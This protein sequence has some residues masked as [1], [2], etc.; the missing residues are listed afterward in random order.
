M[1][2]SLD[3]RNF[4]GIISSTD[5][6]DIPDNCATDS[7]N[8][9]GDVAEGILQSIPTDV[10]D[11][12]N[13]NNYG[14]IS[15]GEFIEINNVYYLIYHDKANNKISVICDFYNTEGLK[16]QL[17]LITGLTSTNVS[18]TKNNR[19]VHIGIDGMNAYWIGYLGRGYFGN[20]YTSTISNI[21]NNSGN[22]QIQTS[23]ATIIRPASA[24][25]VMF[26]SIV[27]IVNAPSNTNAN[28]YWRIS[29]ADH[30]A[31]TYVL[32]GSTF[33]NTGSGGTVTE[34]FYVNY[35]VCNP[36]VADS[37]DNFHIQSIANGTAGSGY[38]QAN[39]YYEWRL[40]AVYDGVQESPLSAYPSINSYNVTVGASNIPY[41]T[42][43][44]RALGAYPTA[45]NTIVDFNR[46]I[47]AINLWRADSIDNS[48][49]NIGLFRKVASFSITDSAWIQD[50]STPSTIN[51][52]LKDYGNYVEINTASG[53]TFSTYR[54]EQSEMVTYKENTGMPE[55][56]TN[57]S[58]NWAMATSGYGYHF[59]VNDRTIYRSKRFRFDMFDW[60]TDFLILPEKP[61]ALSFYEGK[62]YAFS[63]NKT[64]RID[65]EYLS[66]EDIFDDA[67]ALGKRSVHTNEYGMFFANKYG[68]WMLF[69]SQIEE[70]T[71]PIR[72]TK[73][74]GKSWQSFSYQN[75]DEIIITSDAKKGYVLFINDFSYN[76]QYKILVW[77]YLPRTNRWDAWILGEYNSAS[78]N[79]IFKGKDGEIYL[80]LTSTT[81]KLL[82]G[83]SYQAWEWISKNFD[84]EDI[85]KK[86][87]LNKIKLNKTGTISIS[88]D[89]NNSGSFTGVSE[90]TY[91]NSYIYSVRI[92]LNAS[93]GSNTVDS[94]S[95]LFR[96]LIGVR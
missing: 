55:T 43:Q 71:K 22:I 14:N 29:F 62:L 39:T 31:K 66:I 42:I 52:Y 93:T 9:D 35:A 5:E 13:S 34:I 83:A 2:N 40:S 74:N 8:I 70:I 72:N 16:K 45:S 10:A 4:L 37:Q 60:T 48:S 78:S 50:G 95:I 15:A 56:L 20:T 80:S 36:S 49:A 79:G 12:I 91:I 81:Y 53:Y 59:I 7:L 23:S 46:R 87:R 47:T 41:Y 28:G 90:D 30:D 61:T 86:K 26:S 73:T 44:I 89:I 24:S 1:R 64:Y 68:A 75:L 3:I 58:R 63:L 18:I 94:M 77:A 6:S 27:R 32:E 92:K 82:R 85:K 67:G 21:T 96:P 57:S 25:P 17:D 88:A 69:N 54:T 76:E 51:L 11:Q 33:A 65:P 19:Q 84:F 38:F